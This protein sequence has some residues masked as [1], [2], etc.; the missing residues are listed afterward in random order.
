MILGAGTRT[1][2]MV[3]LVERET[4]LDLV[5]TPSVNSDEETYSVASES[6]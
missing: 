4:D 5:V 3:E 1:R 6:M 2:T